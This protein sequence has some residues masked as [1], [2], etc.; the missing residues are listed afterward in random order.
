MAA[1]QSDQ[2]Q[3]MFIAITDDIDNEDEMALAGEYTL[4]LLSPEEADAFDGVMAVGP[5]LRDQFAHWAEH[6]AQLTDDIPPVDPPA[7]M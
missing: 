4:G 2:T 5:D 7:D 6:F 3:R 1:P